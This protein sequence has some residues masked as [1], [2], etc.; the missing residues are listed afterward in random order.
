[1]GDQGWGKDENR[2]LMTSLDVIESLIDS[3][4]YIRDEHHADIT[5]THANV[6][7]HIHI[8]AFVF[9]CTT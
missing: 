3:S 4:M 2:W 1:M 7:G 5:H 6:Y 9:S 8:D